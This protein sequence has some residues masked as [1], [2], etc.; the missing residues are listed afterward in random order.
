MSSS[1]K[2]M[3]V[4]VTRVPYLDVYLMLSSTRE[5]D[6]E[7]EWST[8]RDVPW[9]H[10]VETEDKTPIQTHNTRAQEKRKLSTTKS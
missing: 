10:L 7:R 9:M 1:L 6:D 8:G 2:V 4:P 3:Y 5:E